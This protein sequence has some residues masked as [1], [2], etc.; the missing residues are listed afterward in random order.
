MC[1]PSATEVELFNMIKRID[2]SKILTKHVSWEYKCKFVGRK[3]YSKQKLHNHKCQ[4]EFQNLREQHECKKNY[5]LN[6]IVRTCEN[7]KYLGSIIGDS[8]IMCEEIIE[9]TRT[10]PTNFNEKK[11]NCKMESFYNLLAPFRYLPYHY[12]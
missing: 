4:W 9:E 1:L 2:E 12:Q 8:I 10:I 3:C 6:P 7:D 5:I 11:V